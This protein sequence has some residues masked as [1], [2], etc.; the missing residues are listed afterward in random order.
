MS[1]TIQYTTCRVL[2]CRDKHT[3]VTSGHQCGICRQYGHG[4]IECGNPKLIDKLYKDSINDK[5]KYTEQWCTIRNCKYPWSHTNRAHHC[6]VCNGVNH[7]SQD[8]S[9][10]HGCLYKIKDR[11]NLYNVACP[12]CLQDN[13]VNIVKDKALGLDT[14]CKLC[15]TNNIEIRLPKCKHTL[16][17]GECCVQIDK[18]RL[19]LD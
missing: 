18:N 13:I 9:S 6:S 3:H 1:T 2:G 8:C 15:V 19:N 4:Q 14:L 10:P 11:R 12:L 7:G 16:L 5:L 17:C